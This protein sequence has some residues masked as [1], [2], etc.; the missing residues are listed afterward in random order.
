MNSIIPDSNQSS[1]KWMSPARPI[2]ESRVER[3]Q[4]E[5]RQKLIDAAERLM[6]DGPIDHVQIKHITAQ[7]DVG[8]G[9]FY[10]HFKSKYDIL[11]PIVKA[12]AA[13]WDKQIQVRVNSMDDPAEVMA[14]SG[15]QMSRL[16]QHDSLWRWFLRHSGV[17]VED[18]KS[19]IGAFSARDM[20]K[21]LVSGRFDVPDVDV[22]NSF[23]FGAFVNSLLTSFDSEDP[24]SV[25]DQMMEMLLR[26]LG[27]GDN[28]A[29]ELTNRPL[30]KINPG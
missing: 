16:I 20:N 29:H 4:R 11:I 19:A 25:I 7:A 5:T 21:A 8:H 13:R 12:K 27:I 15:R 26:A 18:M 1:E 10:L 30:D 2:T 17:P 9:T 6:S 22:A 3:K 24:D 28:E 23:L 14:Y